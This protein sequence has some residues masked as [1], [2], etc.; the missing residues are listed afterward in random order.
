[1]INLKQN[2][3][4]FSFSMNMTM[5]ERQVQSNLRNSDLEKNAFKVFVF[6]TNKYY[7]K[8]YI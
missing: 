4:R 3:K 2:S 5:V 6:E 8:E 7:G 1:M